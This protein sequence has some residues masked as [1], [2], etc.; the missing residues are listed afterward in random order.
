MTERLCSYDQEDL[1]ARGKPSP[2]YLKLYEVRFSSF[3]LFP[4][5]RTT[6]HLGE[7]Q[8]GRFATRSFS[9]SLSLTP[10]NLQ[11]WGKGAIGIIVL[12]NVPVE[13]QGLEAKGNAIIDP[14]NSWDAVA[15]FKPAIA[16]AK[17]HVRP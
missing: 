3:L 8:L 5:L 10:L 4:L 13:R 12:G 11:E 2:E 9:P 6:I 14:K 1:D 17:A 15:A 7:Q 16:A